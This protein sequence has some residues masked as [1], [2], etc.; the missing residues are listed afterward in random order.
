LRDLWTVLLVAAIVAGVESPVGG[1][2]PQSQ[3]VGSLCVLPH[4]RKADAR[5]QS[6]EVPPAAENY[7]LRIDSGRWVTLSAQSPVLLA[8]IPRA[9]RHKVFIRG[10][11]RPFSA[12]TFAFDELGSTDLCLA[13]NDLYLIW[14]FHPSSARYAPCRCNGIA[15]IAWTGGPQGLH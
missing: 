6:P 1:Q 10:D 11:G 14:Q 5:G 9:G 15:P 2:S 8:D 4:V 7:S 13:Q 12:F 3:K